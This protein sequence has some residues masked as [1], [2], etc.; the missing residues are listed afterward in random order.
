MKTEQKDVNKVMLC[1]E[2]IKVIFHPKV[3]AKKKKVQFHK[4]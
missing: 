3:N 2:N 4:K 1:Q